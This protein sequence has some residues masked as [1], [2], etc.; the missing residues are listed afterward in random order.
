MLGQKQEN[1]TNDAQLSSEIR[2]QQPRLLVVTTVAATLRAFLLPFARHFR[3][4]GW[5][6]DALA[7]GVSK[8][9]EC[10]DNF[11][12]VYEAGWSRNPLKLRLNL[13]VMRNLRELVAREKYD[14]V[15]VHTPIASFVTR[16]ALRNRI[17]HTKVI[18]TAHGF[19]FHY[20]GNMFKNLVFL[21]LEK[22]AGIWTDAL[23][24]IN[25]E[26]EE[27][28]KRYSIISLD[29]IN[30]MPGIGIDLVSYSEQS[31]TD[32][33][34]E[35]LRTALNISPLERILLQVGEFI[36]R[37]RH[38]D[39]LRAF[40]RVKSHARLV[41]VGDGPLLSAM[42]KLAD[43]LGVANRV[44]FLGYRS[45]I[46]ALMTLSSA[47]ILVSE[48]EGL[49]RCILEAMAIGRPVIGTRVRGTADL[50]ENGAGILVPVGD[51]NAIAAAMNTIL[52]NLQAAQHMGAFGREVVSQY[53]LTHILSLHEDLYCRILDHRS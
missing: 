12:A 7:T 9:A 49:P 17:G 38:G 34:L 39:L 4:K 25:R 2:V 40:A 29:K 14:L 32:N 48:Q 15:H 30:Y 6:V 21:A 44:S 16:L 23:V 20:H 19:H 8:S 52:E 28:A 37:K 26:D 13:R 1:M 47:V 46:P 45:D 22:V 11:N 18:Y 36:P 3:A 35:T 43:C 24:V 50:I 10:L 53:D 27:A 41:L 31:V 5:Q 51:V 42:S 33:T